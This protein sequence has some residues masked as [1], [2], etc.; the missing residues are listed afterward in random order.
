MEYLTQAN[1]VHAAILSNFL[2]GALLLARSPG[3]FDIG[4]AST[5]WVTATG[6]VGHLCYATML[7]AGDEPDG[8]PAPWLMLDIVLVFGCLFVTVLALPDIAHLLADSA[9]GLIGM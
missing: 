5:L 4:A 3:R 9:G 2:Y 7:P 1:A 6:A 8:I